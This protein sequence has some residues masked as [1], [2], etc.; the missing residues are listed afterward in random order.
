ML[1]LNILHNL[2]RVLTFSGWSNTQNN[3]NMKFHNK[4]PRSLR[5]GILVLLIS[6]AFSITNTQAG[7]VSDSASVP[8]TVTAQEISALLTQYRLEDEIKIKHI[9]INIFNK[10]DELIYSEKVCFKTFESDKK[11][12]HR[13]NQSDFIT[14]IDNTRIYITNQ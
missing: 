14:E 9:Q 6:F 11:L 1:A 4:T 7:I 13:I 10:K 2:A 8:F 5:A 12:N 3:N